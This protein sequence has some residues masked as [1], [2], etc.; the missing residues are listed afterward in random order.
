MSFLTGES[1]D[2]QMLA[3]HARS[4][5]LLR[6]A[7]A[8]WPS[9]NIKFAFIEKLLASAAAAGGDAANT[10]RTG[11]AVFNVA[12][13]ADAERFV[14]GNAPQLAQMLEPCFN[15]PRATH[16]ALAGR[17][18]AHVPAAAP[19]RGRGGVPPRDKLLQRRLDE[20]CAKHVAAAVTGGAAPPP[21][22]PDTSVACV[23]TC[24]ARGAEPG[25]WTAPSAPRQALSGSR[26]S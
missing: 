25:W 7:L 20:L 5:S 17:S 19:G 13:D 18:R 2:K 11:L 1:K 3:L 26:T 15:S 6:E 14:S 21:A 9:A 22:A 23:L 10:L 24:A 16:E 4:L 8:T 12:L